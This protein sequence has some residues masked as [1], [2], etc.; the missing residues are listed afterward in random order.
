MKY[1]LYVYVI[2]CVSCSLHEKSNVVRMATKNESI[3]SINVDSAKYEDKILLSSYLKDPK[4]I[5]LENSK[6][7]LIGTIKKIQVYN[8]WIIVLDNSVAKGVFI[9]DIQGNFITRV[10]NLGSGPSDYTEPTDFTINFSNEEI[11]ILD[12]NQSKINK[13]NLNGQYIS[14][15]FF[16]DNNIRA[17]HIQ[18]NEGRLYTD[19]YFS[20]KNEN[21]YLLQELDLQTGKKKKSWL[22]PDLYNKG[23]N[24]LFVVENKAFFSQMNNP[25]LFIQQYMDTIMMLEDGDVIPF[26]TLVGKNLLLKEDLKK[27]IELAKRP[28]LVPIQLMKLNKIHSLKVF[29]EHD[30]FI[31]IEYISGN[32]LVSLLYNKFL[33]KAIV[34]DVIKDDLLFSSD[35]AGSLTSNWGCSTTQGVYCYINPEFVAEFKILAET[36][37]LSEKCDKIDIIRNLPEDSNPVILFYEYKN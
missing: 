16:K 1:C 17:Y 12:S 8:D 2:L 29:M 34:S 24:N 4:V 26:L 27:A 21:N 10:G 22:S 18:Y 7:A 28:E 35:F 15:L 9:F 23:W 5:I 11:Y 30:E 37:C 25:P 20:Q 31:Y 19:A 6:N 33:N 14:S 36:G 3:Y 32:T 13:Y